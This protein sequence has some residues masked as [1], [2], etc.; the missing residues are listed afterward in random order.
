MD[1]AI[2][3]ENLL[4]GLN[5]LYDLQDQPLER[6][7][8]KKLDEMIRRRHADP[9]WTLEVMNRAGVSRVITDCY[10]DPLQDVNTTLGAGYQSVMRM[11][12]FAMSCHPGLR[13]H[14][15]NSP[16]EF[17]E[18]LN[19]ACE[20]FDD[21]CDLMDVTVATL[22]SRNQVG[23]K[24]A[25]A[26]DRYLDFDPPDVDA[27]RRA[28]RHA[29]ASVAQR[30]VF[31]D[32]VVD[33]F[34]ELAARHDVPVQMHLGTA[35][36]RGSHP[37]NVAGLIERHPDTRFLLMHLAYPWSSELLA[38]AFVYRNVWLDLTWSFLLS[39]T[40]FERAFHEAIEILPDESRMMIGG[41]N[42]HA[43]ET[44]ATF[45]LARRLV[46]KVLQEKLDAGYFQQQDA[47]RLAERV[48]SRNAIDFFG[49][50]ELPDG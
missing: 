44:F 49:L 11:N 30:K 5:Q 12:A 36:L 35:I 8:W 20:S 24:N 43:E 23:I 7:N 48:F 2:L 9:S 15:G 46:G 31:G 14:N 38:M 41:D 6:S 47:E 42:W 45:R 21:F 4:A 16:F 10:L 18:R 27:A 3:F 25:L 19:V 33:R 29:D 13:C 22:S 37:M 32:F 34:C 1:R 39:P 28:W 26:Y 50:V 40:H 17:A